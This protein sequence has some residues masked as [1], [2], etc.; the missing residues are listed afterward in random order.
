MKNYIFPV[1]SFETKGK[2]KGKFALGTGFFVTSEG[3]F[4]SAGHNFKHR[5]RD[6]FALIDNALYEI[7][8]I[9]HEYN[10]KDCQIEPTYLDLQIGKV[11]ISKTIDFVIFGEISDLKKGDQLLVSGFKSQELP[12]N[13]LVIQSHSINISVIDID[14]F[15]YSVLGVFKCNGVLFPRR[16]DPPLQHFINCISLN[17]VDLQL[18]GLSGSPLLKD[19]RCYGLLIRK[20]SYLSSNYILS[21][22]KEY[23]IITNTENE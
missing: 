1:I 8:E 3:H 10:E 23:S 19:C 20:D 22:L 7:R 11:E 17:N 2:T 6:F 14:L 18:N 9:C 21:K 5:D 15:Y 13:E 16:K 12:Q 4:V